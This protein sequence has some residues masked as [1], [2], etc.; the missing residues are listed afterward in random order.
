MNDTNLGFQPFGFAGGLYDP[1]TGLVRFG[2]RDY[3]PSIGRW[4]AKDPILFAGGQTNL[5]VYVGN[6]P[7]NFVDPEGRF[8]LPGA[9]IGAGVGFV[10][11]LTGGLITGDV[12]DAI[13]AGSI[14]AVGGFAG[15]AIEVG[16][17]LGAGFAAGAAAFTAVG[18]GEGLGGTLGAS[19]G[20]GLGGAIGGLPGLGLVGVPV[21]GFLAGVGGLGFGLAGRGIEEAIDG[22]WHH[23]QL[24]NQCKAEGF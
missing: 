1:D 16:P 19:F 15:G 6:D 22:Q 11:G 24:Y 14:G 10:V 13:F 8:G 12:S 9:F 17:G 20:G 4:T 2:S 21:G 3:D 7:V 23:D 5:Y 18:Q